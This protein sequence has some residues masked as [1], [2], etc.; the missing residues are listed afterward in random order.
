MV[1]CEYCDG[2]N[3][4]KNGKRYNQTRGL[5]QRYNCKDCNRRFMKGSVTYRMR[6]RR[7]FINYALRLRDKGYTLSQ[8]AERIGGIS[9]QGV[10]RWLQKY[11]LSKGEN[12]NITRTINN[13]GKIYLRKFKIKI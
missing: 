8:I 3:I 5:I 13:K 6:H 7:F 10:L 1:K 12:R 2:S 9:R 4:I 11:R